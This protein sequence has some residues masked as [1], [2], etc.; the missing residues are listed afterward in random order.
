VNSWHIQ[1]ASVE[2]KEEFEVEWG[3]IDFAITR[4][5]AENPQDTSEV[6]WRYI[7]AEEASW[8]VGI[9]PS[10]LNSLLGDDIYFIY[11]WQGLDAIKLAK[12]EDDD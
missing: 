1:P 3:A 9:K 4:C 6:F 7:E 5:K 8:L 10:I 2:I 11:A 12:G